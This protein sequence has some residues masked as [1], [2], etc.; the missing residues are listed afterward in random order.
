ME[1]PGLEPVWWSCAL[2]SLGRRWRRH[3]SYINGMFL[4]DGFVVVNS[5]YFFP[6]NVAVAAKFNDQGW[7]WFGENYWSQKRKKTLASCNPKLLPLYMPNSTGVFYQPWG[8]SKQRKMQVPC[9]LWMLYTSYCGTSFKSGWMGIDA[10]IP[11]V[12]K[13]LSAASVGLSTC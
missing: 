9:W 2:N 12:K 10:F 11:G 1:V 13:C 4:S 7:S 3:C 6:R 8:N 5:P